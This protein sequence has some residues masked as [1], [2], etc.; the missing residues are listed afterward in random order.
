VQFQTN[1]PDTRTS[2]ALAGAFWPSTTSNHLQDDAFV[3]SGS[4]WSDDVD[5]KSTHLPTRFRD[6]VR[7]L[8]SV[9]FGLSNARF[10]LFQLDRA[11]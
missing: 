8:L 6:R 1:P 9:V 5:S 4:A 7:L 11:D 3:Q 2:A 10:A